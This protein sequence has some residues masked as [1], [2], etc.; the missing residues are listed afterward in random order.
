MLVAHQAE[1]SSANV[2]ERS[3]AGLRLAVVFFDEL[4]EHID[5][6]EGEFDDDRILALNR[7]H[8]RLSILA[9]V[10]A[11]RPISSAIP[12]KPIKDTH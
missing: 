1:V 9:V 6:L 12:A 2:V 4:G 8:F 3:V 11:V 7:D 10:L 5:W